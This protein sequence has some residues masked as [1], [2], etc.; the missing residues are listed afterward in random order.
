MK[1]QKLNQIKPP[2]SRNGEALMTLMTNDDTDGKRIRPPL[3]GSL[4][5]EERG[6]GAVVVRMVAVSLWRAGKL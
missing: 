2:R 5:G 1:T 3:S 4:L 6:S